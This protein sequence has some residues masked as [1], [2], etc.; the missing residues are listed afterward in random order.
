MK[1]TNVFRLLKYWLRDFG[2]GS[3]ICIHRDLRPEEPTVTHLVTCHGRYHFVNIQSRRNNLVIVNVH[4]EPDGHPRK[5]AV[6]HS[7]FQHVLEITQSDYTRR[8]FS[9][10]GIIRTL[11]RIDRVLIK[12]PMVEAR[13]FPCYSHVFKKLGNRTIPSDPQQYASSSKSQQIED[14]RANVFPAGCPNIP[15]SV[16]FFAAFSQRQ[17]FLS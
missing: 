12:L 15:F 7:F 3:A 11:S 4:F 1:R 17:Q 9:V 5:T 10:L 8:D 14:T 6:F 16:R 2:R 13:N